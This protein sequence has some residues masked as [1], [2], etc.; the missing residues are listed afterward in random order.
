VV[1]GEKKENELTLNE[2]S[3]E[4]LRKNLIVKADPKGGVVVVCTRQISGFPE[5][6]GRKGEERRRW[7][8]RR[9]EKRYRL[10]RCAV[11]KRCTGPKK[12]TERIESRG[13]AQ[14]KK[15][16]MSTPTGLPAHVDGGRESLRDTPGGSDD[17]ARKA[18]EVGLEMEAI[19]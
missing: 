10:E 4:R 19:A 2:V 17:W 5:G 13:E 1:G 18:E 9:K 12:W 14:S 3:P 7:D 15:I 6:G 16:P 11:A 8:I